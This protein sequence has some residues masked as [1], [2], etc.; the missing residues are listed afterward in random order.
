MITIPQGEAPLSYLAFTLPPR[1][2]T[3]DEVLDRF[4]EYGSERMLLAISSVGITAPLVGVDRL[5][6]TPDP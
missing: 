3:P 1:D 6:L 2:V 4:L 5:G